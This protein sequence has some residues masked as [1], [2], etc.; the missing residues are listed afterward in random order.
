[1]ADPAFAANALAEFNAV[2][3]GGPY[4]LAMSNSAVF[5]GLPNITADYRSIASRI[6]AMVADGS[7]ASYLPADYRTDPAMI[8]GYERQL[9]VLADLSE[10]PDAP[11]MEA[12]WATGLS[13]RAINLHPLSRGTVRLNT[14]S[15]LSQPVV[16][17]RTGSNPVDMDVYLAHTKYLRTLLD[18]ATMRR[19]GAVEVTPGAAVQ[20]DDALVEYI[21]GD[22]TFSYMHPCCTAAMMPRG[23]GGVVGADLA[24]HGAAGLRVVD[25]SVLPLLPSSHLSATAYAV[26]EKVSTV[27]ELRLCTGIE[28]CS[29]ANRCVRRPTSLSGNGRAR[30]RL[31]REP[32]R[33]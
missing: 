19:Y 3:A 9:S 17:Y 2:P 33:R 23:Q 21:K 24:V 22:V 5:L 26:G 16:D 8:R 6:R 32:L 10:D 12:P 28:V 30:I 14:S 7:A 20:G 4:T 13:F 29:F 25:M 11:S 31:Q 27:S 15:P 18:T 1:M